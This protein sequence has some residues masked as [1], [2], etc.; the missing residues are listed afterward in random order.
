MSNITGLC[1][2]FSF[3]KE[4]I[5]GQTIKTRL[6]AEEMQDRY[7]S[8]N[9]ICLDS[10]NWKSKKFKFLFQC[11]HLA[12]KSRHVVIFPAHKGIKA[13]V[14]LYAFLSVFLNFK[15]HYIIIGAWLGDLL[16]KNKWLIPFLKKINYIYAETN[17]LKSILEKEYGFKRMYILHN[18]KNLNII[19]A[20][21]IG[22]KKIKGNKLCSLSRVEPNKGIEDAVKAVNAINKMKKGYKLSLDIYGPVQNDYKLKFMQILKKY[23]CAQYKGILDFNETVKV[24]KN[25]YLLLFPTRY[26]T[27]GLP[28]TILD[29]YAAGV[30][31]VASRWESCHDVIIENKTG[32]SYEFN[33]FEDFVAKML[34]LLENPEKVF[35]MK[36][37]CV[38]EAEKYASQRA[39]QS[40]FLNIDNSK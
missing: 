18:F 8:D 30:P 29:A 38:I 11:I 28:G 35:S 31:V 26:F 21:S 39:L 17:T 5:G 37:N 12:Q 24:I 36:R 14:P 10:D 23:P 16:K 20:D 2:N 3:G 33:N 32:T 13:L 22:I 7:G 25:Y 15:T 6:I 34:F 4:A 1:G 27:E 40:L 9:I 19:D